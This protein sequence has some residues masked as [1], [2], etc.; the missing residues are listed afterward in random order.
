M[1]EQIKITMSTNQ[2]TFFCPFSKNQFYL[3]KI[4]QLCDCE[5]LELYLY[6]YDGLSMACADIHNFYIFL[7]ISGI[8][9]VLLPT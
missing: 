7:S 5:L 4:D 9:E 6:C 3:G 1:G 8:M 2:F